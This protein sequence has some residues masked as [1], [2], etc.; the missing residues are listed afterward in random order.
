MAIY[1]DG[2][3]VD[4]K[5]GDRS[6]HRKQYEYKEDINDK[7]YTVKEGDNIT[8]LAFRFYKDPQKWFLIADVNK[9]FNP[10]ILEIGQELIIPNPNRYGRN[11]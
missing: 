6:L 5:E 3:V 11:N 1:D 2:F 8:R 4:Y 7:L 9:L 10:F